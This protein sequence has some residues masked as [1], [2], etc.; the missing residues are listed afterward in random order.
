VSQDYNNSALHT[1]PSTVDG[2]E[3]LQQAVVTNEEE[4]NGDA[5][6][7]YASVQDF[8][9]CAA[10]DFE[11]LDCEQLDEQ[12]DTAAPTRCDAVLGDSGGVRGT[13][14]G[15]ETAPPPPS[16]CVSGVMPS[17]TDR[18]QRRPRQPKQ[19]YGR[20]RATLCVSSQIGCQMGCTFCAT[21][22]CVMGGT[23]SMW[24]PNV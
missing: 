22:V 3:L 18:S 15:S 1:P 6:D 14:P 5:N 12:A 21:G 11:D 24:C 13:N 17:H 2:E 9:S 10:S 7:D 19:V 16:S 20:K 23:S 4:D 8:H